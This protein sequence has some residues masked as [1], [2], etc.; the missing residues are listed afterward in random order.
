MSN[1]RIALAGNPNCGKTT[2]FN[3]LTG[4]RQRV[5]NW[6]G[7][8][9]EKKEGSLIG[10]NE[11][12]IQDL[13]GIYSLSPYSMEEIVTRD[14]LLKEKPE[15]IINIIDATNLERNLYLST[16]L[17]EA[18]IP[19]VIAL[20]MIDLVQKN[21]DNIDISKL[22]KKL[23]CPIIKTS[24]IRGEGC[25]EVAEVA[26]S[27]AKNKKAP[28]PLPC[29]SPLVEEALKN[30][31]TIIKGRCEDSQLRWIS[32]KIFERDEKVLDSIKISVTEKANIDAILNELENKFDNDTESIIANDRYNYIS[33]IIK[34]CVTRKNP[35]ALTI[36]DK[37]D[38]VV[39]NRWLALPIFALVMWGV[40]YLSIQTIGTIGTDWVNDV[41]FGEWV[42]GWIEALLVKLNTAAW[43][44]SLIL[45]GIVAGIGAILGFLPQMA[46]LFICLALL[47]DCGYMARIAFVMDRIFRKFG[48]SGKS[49]IPLL[50]A[51]GCGIPGILAARTIENPKDHKMTIL[52]T[53]FIPCSAKL[54]IIALIA[55][56]FFPESSWVAPSAYFIGIAA[57]IIS[58]IMLKKTKLFGG[59]PAPFVMELPAYHRPL[60]GSI[61]L[62]TWERLFAFI[63]RAGTIIF[64][65]CVLIWFMSSYS[66]SLQSVDMSESILA[67]IG[68][69]AAPLF[70]PLGWGDWKTTVAT[71]TG[72][73]AKENLVGTLG[74]L[75]GMEE[76]AEDGNE[77]W[78]QL[79]LSLTFMGGYSLLIFNLLC[80]PCFA[81]I[82]SI[83]REAG[84]AKWT[85]GIVA[86]QT[87]LAYI[88][89]LIIYQFGSLIWIEGFKPG[90][91]TIIAG[92]FLLG[93][94]FQ[95]FR[96]PAW[97]TN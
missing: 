57:V 76:V 63:K 70:A 82:G 93:I 38:R 64:A 69:I 73:L 55:G 12:L 2:L 37:I 3:K 29:F 9:V 90:L 60:I 61:S 52:V 20:N 56:A 47:E 77:Y 46:V 42:P 13:P 68:N 62:K 88:F 79:R 59:E 17:R 6:P 34:E 75:Y 78:E 10:Q 26:I 16:Q 66:W 94:L 87:I 23:G 43:L 74:I 92:I 54:P 44:Q 84:S 91:G 97:K 21:G 58:G 31:G 11:V 39:T 28:E 30:I 15:A 49:F 80:A 53:T 41:L 85:L 83:H 48:L 96:K 24:A 95:L 50:V 65:S 45:D 1:I 36:S 86:Y 72:L 33:E 67:S 27:L 40:Y 19:V 8:T 35:N 22:S 5:A 71:V 81:A 18:G 4:A 14:Y 89:A 7:V 32:V 25:Q 51:N